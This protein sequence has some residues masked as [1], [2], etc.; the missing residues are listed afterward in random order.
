MAPELHHL[1]VVVKVSCL[2]QFIHPSEHIRS[3]YPNPVSG[4][5]LEGCVVV[6]QEVKKVKR[7]DQ[8][9]IVIRH[10]N[11]KT[12]E[13]EFIKL[14]AVKHYFKETEE[15]DT[16]LLFNAVAEVEVD[17][18]IPLPEVVDEALNRQSTENNTL[19][20]LDRQFNVDNDNEPAPENVPQPTDPME[21]VLE[22]ELGHDR[23]AT[24]N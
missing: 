10:D 7:K 18:Q 11:F 19:E 20:A 4:H 13:D 3:R 6:H 8:L 22:T 15:G 9:C 16:D 21:R 23:Y 12:T 1:G 14:H 5:H 2:S 17:L 24:A